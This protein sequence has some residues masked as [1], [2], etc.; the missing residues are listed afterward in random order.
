MQG[1]TAVRQ[2]NAAFHLNPQ[3]LLSHAQ[4]ASIYNQ[5]YNSIGL[6]GLYQQLTVLDFISGI[7]R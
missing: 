4:N 6:Y 5:L 7:T 3:K 1:C 2:G